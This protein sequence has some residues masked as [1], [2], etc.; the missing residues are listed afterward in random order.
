MSAVF[1]KGSNRVFRGVLLTLVIGGVAAPVALMA[2][3]RTPY[4]TGATDRVEQPIPFDHRHHVRDDGIDCRYCH[5]A[6][7]RSPSA[8]LPSSELCMNCHSQVLNDSPILEPV[9]TSVAEDRPIPWVRVDRLP[10]FVYFDHSAH[11]A[12][13]VGCEVCHGR[14]DLMPRVRQVR[15]L[16]MGWCLDCHRDPASR[17]RPPDEVTTMGYA[18]TSRGKAGRPSRGPAPTSCTTCHR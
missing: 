12:Q 18:S 10:D 14:V 11:I 8:G 3:V 1:S 17:I 15:P 13:G 6:A 4:Q 16:T 7:E 5:W 2:W 9:R